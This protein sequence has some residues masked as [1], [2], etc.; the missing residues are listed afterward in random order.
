MYYNPNRQDV[1]KIK[2][3]LYIAKYLSTDQDENLN[4]K[5][6]YDTPKKY[7]FN[8]MPVNQDSE[9]KE[10]GELVTSMKVAVITEKLKYYNKFTEFD[11][12]YL[13]GATPNNELENGDNANYR[14]YAIR[15]QN[16]IIRVYFL[17]IVN[18]Q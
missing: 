15:K 10:F 1:L 8:V 11:K 13:D 16:S 4:Q 17:K 14:V 7:Y 18:N 12:A 2:S 3:K 6:V 5:Q 9:I